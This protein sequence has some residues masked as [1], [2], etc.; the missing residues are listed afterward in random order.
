M[1]TDTTEKGLEAH[2][3][4]YLARENGYLVRE[5]NVYNASV[6]LDTELLFNF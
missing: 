2:I 1:Q 5:N 6:C 3:S 4:D